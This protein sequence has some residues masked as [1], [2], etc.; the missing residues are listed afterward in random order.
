MRQRGVTLGH[1]VLTWTLYTDQ[2]ED[3]E[4]G[5]CGPRARTSVCVGCVGCVG[6]EV[7]PLL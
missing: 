1:A 6:W 2:V 4:R 3:V 5:D 7:V